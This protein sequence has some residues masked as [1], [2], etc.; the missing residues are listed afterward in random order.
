MDPMHLPNLP[1]FA[2]SAMQRALTMDPVLGGDRALLLGLTLQEGVLK[3]GL[4]LIAKDTLEQAVGEG[5]LLLVL[6]ETERT[7]LVYLALLRQGGEEAV[8]LQIDT[9][10][11]GDPRIYSF[12]VPLA[13]NQGTPTPTGEMWALNGHAAALLATPH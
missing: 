3:P 4:Q 9:R 12:G 11:A 10:E 5:R 1:D 6:S 2:A 8:G 7:A 13:V